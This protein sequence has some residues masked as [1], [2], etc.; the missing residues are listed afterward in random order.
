MSGTHSTRSENCYIF[1]ISVN[2]SIT[3]F[4]C[5]DQNAGGRVRSTSS[6]VVDCTNVR[7]FLMRIKLLEADDSVWDSER[8]LRSS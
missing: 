2:V 6:V 4:E 7:R 3:T 1:D 5:F 8:G